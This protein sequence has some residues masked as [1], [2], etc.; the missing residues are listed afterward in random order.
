[1]TGT[2]AASEL[3]GSTDYDRLGLRL[4]GVHDEVVRALEPRAGVRWL[5][6]A[7]GT[8]EVAIRAARAG[9]DVT[10]IDIAPRML[11]RARAKAGDLR[12]RF[13]EGDAERLPYGDASFDVVSSVF[14]SMFAPDHDAVARELAR[15]SRPQARLGFTAWE[16]NPKLAALYGA[17]GL[18]LPEGR[19]PFE[20]G[21]EEYVAGLLSGDFEL[22][23]D[24]RTWFLVEPDG[25][26]VWELWSSAAPPFRSL[27]ERLAPADLERFHEAYVA[28][29]ERYRDGDAVAVPRA[30]LLVLGRR[31]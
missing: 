24:H 29:C 19:K 2:Q 27:L 12:I 18:D 11:E 8:G 30:Y 13:D 6:V 26:A 28:Y 4:A 15:V 3:W 17:F 23:L 9:A 21:R 14:G 7:T 5:D 16:P 1:M 25:E 31:R 22:E 20:W 10:G